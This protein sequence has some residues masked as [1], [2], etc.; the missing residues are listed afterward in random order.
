MKQRFIPLAAATAALLIATG[1]TAATR[2]Q[3]GVRIHTGDPAPQAAAPTRRAAPDDYEYEVALAP[4]GFSGAQFGA[5]ETT[6]GFSGYG[7]YGDGEGYDNGF[8]R[9]F[10][11]RDDDRR[12][13]GRRDRGVRRLRG[14]IEPGT[15]GPGPRV[16]G[17]R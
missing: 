10:G 17:R 4:S 2:V 11:F 14:G 7:Y 9:G 8:G 3:N 13:S 6:L 15:S 12:G 5:D 16:V 1:A